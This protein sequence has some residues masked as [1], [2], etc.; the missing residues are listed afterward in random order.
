MLCK[1][2]GGIVT[3]QGGMLSHAAIVSREL[4]IPCVVGTSNATEIIK[5]GDLVEIDGSKGEVWIIE[6]AQRD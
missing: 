1:K 6:R 3:D 2:A 5:G 4:N